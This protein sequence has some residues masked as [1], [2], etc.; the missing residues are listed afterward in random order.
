MRRAPPATV[1]IAAGNPR[2]QQARRHGRGWIL[3]AGFLTGRQRTDAYEVVGG[4]IGKLA[5]ALTART[6]PG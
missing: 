3:A 4:D 6:A 1:R 5:R 2:H